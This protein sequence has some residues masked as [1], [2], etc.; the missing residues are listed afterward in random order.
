MV[1]YVCMYKYIEISMYIYIYISS[2]PCATLKVQVVLSGG[3]LSATADLGGV[4]EPG[5]GGAAWVGGLGP[6]ADLSGIS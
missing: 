3:W 1:Q 6:L 2:I 5:R 4:A